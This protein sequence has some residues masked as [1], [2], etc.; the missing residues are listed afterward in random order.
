[1]NKRDLVEKI[2]NQL[3][4]LIQ[5]EKF[6]EQKS[7]DKLLSTPDEMFVVGSE[8][9]MKD[10]EGNNEPVLD[11]DY[12][13]DNGVKIKVVGGK[14]KSMTSEEGA[15]DEEELQKYTPEEEEK[16]K[17]DGE[18]EK[19]EEDEEDKDKMTQDEKMKE[20][21]EK[22]QAMEE[23]IEKM[24]KRFEEVEKEKEKMKVEL[25][26]ISD[27]PSTQK[28]EGGNAEFKSIE[29]KSSSLAPD[30]LLIRERVRKHNR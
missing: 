16:M 22:I 7:G 4:S 30:M 15:E 29:E 24:G 5:T 12:T 14:I 6:A 10:E 19:M 20:C 21:M 17:E 11:G 2:K 13:F 25:Q 9:F 28:I 18:E 23:K 8:V 3:K 27:Q 26:K 1:M